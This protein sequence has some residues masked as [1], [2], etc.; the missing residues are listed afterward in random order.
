MS[1]VKGGK[2][3]AKDRRLIREGLAR[4]HEKGLRGGNPVFGY[5]PDRFGNIVKN[6]SEQRTLRRIRTL[7]N[8]GESLRTIVQ[9]LK[10]EKHTGRSGKPLGL[11]QVA[12]IV[13]TF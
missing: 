11:T 4:R 7:H 1:N 2:R 9:V 3:T 10:G 8:R 5:G 12:R 6:K 13:K